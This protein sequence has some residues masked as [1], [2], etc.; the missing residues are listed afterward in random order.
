MKKTIQILTGLIIV[1]CLV[2][3][4]WS[5]SVA[6]PAGKPLAVVD[7]P[8]YTFDPVPDG[9]HVSHAFVVK[10]SGD[11]VLNILDVRPP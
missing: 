11:A 7:Q 3:S 10:N 2:Q 4:A 5:Q 8:T 6:A 1:F 9:T